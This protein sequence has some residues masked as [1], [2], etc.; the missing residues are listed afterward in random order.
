MNKF[1][2]LL[3]CLILLLAPITGCLEET[4]PEDETT[5][6]EGNNEDTLPDE[7]GTDDN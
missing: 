3:F 4:T 7:G 2:T 6:E 5:P 1:L